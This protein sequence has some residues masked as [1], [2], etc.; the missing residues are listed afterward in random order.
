MEES[1]AAEDKRLGFIADCVLRTLKLKPDRWERCVSDEE[2]SQVLQG[3]LDTAEQE[4]LVVSMS[5]AGLLEPTTSFTASPKSKAVYFMKRDKAALSPRSIKESLV[6]GDLSSAPLDQ[7]SALVGEV[8]A[9]LLSNTINHIK[10]PQVV[11][12][13]IRQHI[14]SLTT[15]LLVVSGQVR[16]KTLLA[17]P[18]GVEKVEQSALEADKGRGTVD[19][20]IIHSLE[21]TVIEWSHQIHTVLKKDS[22]EAVLGG[23]NPTPHAEL[24][25]WKNR[26]ADLECLHYQLNSCKVKQIK[27]WLE[28]VESSYYPAFMNMQRE[29]LAALEEA[30]DVCVY[31]TPL[32]R[33]FE[34]LENVEFPDVKGQIKAVMHTICL[35]WTNSKHYNTP[36]RLIVLLQETCNLLVQQVNSVYLFIIFFLCECLPQDLQ[37]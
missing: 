11:S 4:A 14:H 17:L 29:V 20:G 30:K 19:K 36:G 24:L 25:F 32:Q 13:D 5:T 23:K 33:L 28:A 31:L 15:S 22:S 1:P 6:Y 37:G 16:G 26:Y 34:E 2:S 7:F 10:W 8:V 18:A 35:V 3:F 21:S 27:A 9:P 12:Q